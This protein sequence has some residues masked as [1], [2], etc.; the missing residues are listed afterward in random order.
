MKR[1]FALLFIFF[2]VAM[3]F[4]PAF[5]QASV[6]E[7]SWITKAPM[8]QARSGLGVIA[9]NGCI[10]A[11]GGTQS[12]GD[13]IKAVVGTNEQYNMTSDAWIYK[14]SMPTAR[15]FF[16]I[17]T[18]QGKIYCF[19]GVVGEQLIDERS[20]FYVVNS[21]NAVEVYDS[22]T[23][24]WEIKPPMPKGGGMYM[25]AQVICGKIYVVNSPDIYVYDPVNG[26]WAERDNLPMPRYTAVTDNKIVATYAHEVTYPRSSPQYGDIVQQIMTY[27]PETN[28]I[29]Q[30]ND[31]PIA[32]DTGGVG[33]TIG[34]N[35]PVR[36]YVLGG[37]LNQAYDPKTGNWM[38]AT[39]MLTARVDMGVVVVND[40]L[41]VIGG[42]I[43]SDG[44]TT[45]VNE[46]YL[47]IGY[48]TISSSPTASSST[49]S[50]SGNQQPAT[51]AFSVLI[52]VV[53]VT[54]LVAAAMFLVR[55]RHV[56]E[57]I[58]CRRNI[59]AMLN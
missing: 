59:D 16:A 50:A 34:V 17:A 57:N 9:A 54:V 35:A 39:A 21:T 53:V 32:V 18:Y 25:S 1:I 56:A 49:S 13:F 44:A 37:S 22:L 12:G 27:D 10:Y 26:T 7:D 40:T 19:G 46:Q 30:G 52:V 43:R 2:M 48:D 23:D 41:Y 4:T 42:Y 38:T 33:A 45:S 24:T 15:A 8:Q 51:P 58:S 36:V 29:T 3:V 5:I 20:G 6:T 28:N 31:N 47:P 55:R 14:A 11:I